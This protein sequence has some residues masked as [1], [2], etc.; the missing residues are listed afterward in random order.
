[1]EAARFSGG[2]DGGSDVGR[3]I[4]TVFAGR[5]QNLCILMYYLIAAAEAGIV[6]EIHLWDFARKD[7]DRQFLRHELCNQSAP[8]Y[9]RLFAVEN[10][11]SWKEYYYHYGNGAY[12]RDVIIKCDDD[13]VFIDLRR[14]PEM[15][16]YV[17][18]K[19]EPGLVFA[20]IINNGVAAHYQQQD[21]IIP[22]TLSY[23]E[24]PNEGF[25]GTLW[26]CGHKAQALHR[27]FLFH[28]TVF[29]DAKFAKPCE[30]ISTRFS[31]NFFAV[32]GRHWAEHIQECYADDE[33]KLTS[34]KMKDPSAT[35][36]N[37]HNEIYKNCVVSHLAFYRQRETGLDT[38]YLCQQYQELAKKFISI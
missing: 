38:D 26:E 32:H 24:Y 31:I 14:L 8:E 28:P 5:K 9:L 13:I 12:D 2:G 20:N 25:K 33:E 29:L 1:M 6:D 7:E 19:S 11:H 27:L 15:V 23:F 34:G 16:E 3:T 22:R 35:A 37:F 4:V 18:Q 17:R 21:G 36:A 10:L 30:R